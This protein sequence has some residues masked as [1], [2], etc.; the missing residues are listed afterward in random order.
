M[1]LI[2]LMV[3]L[4]IE[5]LR[6]IG[7][8]NDGTTAAAVRAGNPNNRVDERRHGAA[9]ARHET[10]L[11]TAARRRRVKR[12]TVVV[13]GRG[14]PWSTGGTVSRIDQHHAGAGS[15]KTR[16]LVILIVVVANRYEKLDA[17]NTT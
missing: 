11:D 13:A 1:I 9:R 2:G 4:A 14:A 6:L 16:W 12:V 8:S 15:P 3:M 7:A 5:L 17:L 10:P